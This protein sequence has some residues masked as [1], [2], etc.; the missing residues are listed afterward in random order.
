MVNIPGTDRILLHCPLALHETQ[1]FAADPVLHTV[2]SARLRLRGLLLG[3]L[4]LLF[5]GTHAH[6]QQFNADNQ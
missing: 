4:A 2:T 6:A 5:T 1:S 3:C